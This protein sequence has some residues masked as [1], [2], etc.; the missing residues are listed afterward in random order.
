MAKIKKI[1]ILLFFLI[2]VLSGTVFLSNALAQTTTPA[3]TGATQ[4]KYQVPF[5]NLPFGTVAV[6]SINVGEYIKALYV[7]GSALVVVLA[8]I[9]IMVSGLQWI[10]S[11]GDSGKIT[12]AKDG[13]IKAIIGLLIALFAIFILQTISPG[14]TLGPITPTP[15]TTSAGSCTKDADCPSTAHCDLVTA[16]CL[17]GASGPIP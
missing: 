10:T 9:M 6:E 7:F 4:F 14:I 16:S 5:G 2:L 3:D 1:S 12:K 8:I 11:G 15:V 17:P 13:L